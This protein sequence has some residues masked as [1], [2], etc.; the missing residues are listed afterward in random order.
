MILSLKILAENHVLKHGAHRLE[1]IQD[2]TGRV[3]IVHPLF[4]VS[5]SLKYGA[6]SSLS[7]GTHV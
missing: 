7:D 3:E 2:M 5:S 6:L 1:Q 4:K